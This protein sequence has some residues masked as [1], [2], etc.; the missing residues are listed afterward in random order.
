MN[1]QY[2]TEASSDID[3]ENEYEIEIKI[4]SLSLT[5]HKLSDTELFIIFGD[6][7]KRITYEEGHESMSLNFILHSVPSELSHKLLKILIMLHIVSID[8][9]PKALGD[10]KIKYQPDLHANL[11]E[12]ISSPQ[13]PCSLK[14]MNALQ[15]Q[16]SV[17]IFVRNQLRSIVSFWKDELWTGRLKSFSVLPK[18]SEI[19]IV[20]GNFT[21]RQHSRNFSKHL[22]FKIE[23]SW[24]FFN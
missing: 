1:F 20:T 21:P 3:L 5:Q 12:F 22:T 16:S 8:P 14:W 24:K 2:K 6:F 11:N 13:A 18:I 23:L 4:K 9:D 7:V 15:M 10:W 17:V 19:R